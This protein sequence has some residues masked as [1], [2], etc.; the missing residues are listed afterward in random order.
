[1]ATQSQTGFLAPEGYEQQLREELGDARIL[2][3]YGRFLLVE[4]AAEPAAW[5]AN[6]DAIAR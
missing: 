1:M 6:T 3:T 4:G 2:A 5:A